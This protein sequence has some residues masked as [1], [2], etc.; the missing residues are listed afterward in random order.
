MFVAA[1][2]CILGDYVWPPT[3][4]QQPITKQPKVEPKPGDQSLMPSTSVVVFEPFA[5]SFETFKVQLGKPQ[6]QVVRD[7]GVY[8]AVHEQAY[9]VYFKT[10]LGFYILDRQNPKWTRHDDPRLGH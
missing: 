4:Q 7:G 3:H 1:C 8:Y 10:L 6:G 9:V 5:R 2:L